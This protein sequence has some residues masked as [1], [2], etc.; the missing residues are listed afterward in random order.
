M[1]AMR[2]KPCYLHFRQSRKPFTSRGGRKFLSL[3]TSFVFYALK[4]RHAKCE[5]RC[6]YF[7]LLFVFF[8]TN[9]IY[10]DGIVDK[11]DEF[12]LEGKRRAATRRLIHFNNLSNFDNCQIHLTFFFFWRFPLSNFSFSRSISIRKVS[13][14]D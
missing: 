3:G 11:N 7:S 10:I 13:A 2:Y 4:S 14:C 9:I 6:Q 8:Y 5:R 1:E 12:R